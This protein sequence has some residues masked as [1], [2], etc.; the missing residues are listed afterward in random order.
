MTDT[1]T[2]PA[3]QAEEEWV[4]AGTRVSSKG[5]RMQ[6]FID[7]ADGRERVWVETATYVVGGIYTMTV[8]RP[9]DG[10]TSRHGKPVY[11]G[12]RADR[13]ERA[14]LEVESEHAERRL[15]RLARERNHKR[16]SAIGEACEPIVALAKT[17]RTFEDVESLCASVRRRIV[18][19]W[20]K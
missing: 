4:A 2:V 10:T 16:E 8:S 7:P 18:D 6:A 15:R 9:G 19:G 13:E 17:M 20:A 11:T 1:D 5:K 12:R 3:D 14:R